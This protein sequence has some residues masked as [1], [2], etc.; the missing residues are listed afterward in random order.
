MIILTSTSS[1]TLVQ[2]LTRKANLGDWSWNVWTE[3]SY[4]I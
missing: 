3:K 4:D 2:I 1:Y